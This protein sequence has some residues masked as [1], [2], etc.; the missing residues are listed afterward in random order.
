MR[1]TGMASGMDTEATVKQMMKPYTM[2]VDKMKQDRQIVSWRQE[3][4]R[5][6]LSDTA[7]ITDTY[8]NN[9]K[10]DTNMLS[11]NNYA[12]FD[13][14]AVNSDTTKG[15]GVS[16][17]TSVGAVIGNYS[18]VVNQ[19]ATAAKIESAN[20]IKTTLGGEIDKYTT[21]LSELG[22]S[23]GT[24]TF[25]YNG[26]PQTN[27]SITVL[28]GDTISQLMDKINQ[29]TSGAVKLNFS[30]LTKSFS[31]ESLQ[32]G[33]SA[34]LK[35]TEGVAGGVLTG[36]KL[37]STKDANGI[38]KS[39]VS[40]DLIAGKNAKVTITP[41][42]S[43]DGIPVTKPGNTFSIDGV[44][45]TLTEE[46]TTNNITVTGNSQ[47][48]Y[49][50]IKGFIDKYNELVEKVSRKTDEKKQYKYL[51]LSDEQKK[52]MKE[53]EIKQWEI[54]AKQG[55]LKGDS[56]LDNMLSSM[57]SA[58][59]QG[60]EG[61]GIYLS[62]IGLSTSAD[63]TQRGKIIIDE[64]KLKNAIETRG[65]QVA[66]LFAKQST[67]PYSEGDTSIVRNKR[68]SEQGIFQR[69]NDIIQDY[70][71]T[72]GKKGI[73]IQKAGVKGDIKSILSEDIIKKDKKINEM[74]KSLSARENRFYM[75][76]S[77]LEVAMNK[78]NSQSN[79]LTQQLSG[80]Q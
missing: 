11:K 22:I 7:T 49:D 33:E 69:I 67:I 75:Q 60:V 51:P 34:S 62:D 73:L 8:F 14:K 4:Y 31:L 63:T 36:L 79:W 57:R 37:N 80:G 41:P 21:K 16:A 59:F 17:T 5:D 12:G 56:N 6:I 39:Y 42:G 40:G 53:D 10:S 76:F 13:V 23:D 72:T 50:K 35:V 55:L 68:N 30:E 43:T 45:Y 18:V 70:T 48:T 19:L 25:D 46:K 26:P 77:K 9:L 20:E 65:E 52:D 74:I 27:K 24:L 15:A 78:L 1:I 38:A 64:K 3:L 47:K 54:K 66:N 29:G 28:A 61:E 71:R 2:R 58:F 44:N 32:I